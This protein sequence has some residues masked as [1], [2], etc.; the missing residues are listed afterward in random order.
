VVDNIKIYPEGIGYDGLDFLQLAQD[1][2]YRWD[3]RNTEI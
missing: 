3:I 1:G 2:I